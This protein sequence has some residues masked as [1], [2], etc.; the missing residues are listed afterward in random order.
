MIV[1]T[2]MIG[3]KSSASQAL[4]PA[5]GTLPENPP[6]PETSTPNQLKN[7]KMKSRIAEAPATFSPGLSLSRWSINP[8]VELGV[9]AT[10]HLHPG[11]G[12]RI[13]EQH[14]DCHRSD[15]AGHWSD[16]RGDL[17]DRLEVDVTDQPGVRAVDSDVDHDRP[18]LDRVGAQ[19]AR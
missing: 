16:C 18:R 13:D 8:P 1:I 9:G 12:Q 19:Q 6:T 7:M 3:M 10:L 15:P 14:R 4:P 11:S 5:P 17:G 2:R